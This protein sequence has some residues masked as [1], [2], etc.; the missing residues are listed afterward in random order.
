[1]NECNY[2]PYFDELINKVDF[3]MVC[4]LISYIEP[5]TCKNLA[6]GDTNSSSSSIYSVKQCHIY[7]YLYIKYN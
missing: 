1:M 5:N 3:K 2:L 7:D 6:D 4:T